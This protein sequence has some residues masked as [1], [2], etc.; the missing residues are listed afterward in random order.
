VR[1]ANI[2]ANPEFAA[3]IQ[4]GGARFRDLVRRQQQNMRETAQEKER[5]IEVRCSY[6]LMS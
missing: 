5:Q 1:R 2:E 3:A 4:A 6:H